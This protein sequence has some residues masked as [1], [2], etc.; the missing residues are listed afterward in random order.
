[1]TVKLY[2]RVSMF[3]PE[4]KV[5]NSLSLGCTVSFFFKLKK[6]RNLERFPSPTL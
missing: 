1:M 4:L 2:S 6:G 5:P 3:H